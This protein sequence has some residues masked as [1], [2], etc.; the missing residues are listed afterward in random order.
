MNEI[1]LLINSID[2]AI[3]KHMQHM[4]K[5]SEAIRSKDPFAY[6]VN[7]KMAESWQAKAL[8]HLVNPEL[9]IN[10]LINNI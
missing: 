2:W 6:R 10:H 9:K 7:K 5:A 8:A 3:Y 1:K 4:D